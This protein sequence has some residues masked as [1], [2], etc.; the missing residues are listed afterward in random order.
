MQLAALFR[1]EVAHAICHVHDVV[2]F[3]LGVESAHVGDLAGLIIPAR[4]AL[5]CA[6]REQNRNTQQENFH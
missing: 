3:V 6:A 1:M 5:R 2:N 4:N